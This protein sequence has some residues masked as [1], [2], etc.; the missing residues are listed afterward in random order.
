MAFMKRV[1][2][3][4]STFRLILRRLGWIGQSGRP[5][6]TLA[7]VL[8]ACMFAVTPGRA[9]AVEEETHLF[10]EALSLT[11]DCQTTTF[12]L[13]A[14]PGCPGGVHPPSP[15]R[16]PEGVAVDA[17]GNRYVAS[18]GAR[19]DGSEARIDVF[20]PS[21]L[22]IT[23]LVAAGAEAIAVD[24]DGNLYVA[25]TGAP[26]LVR[27]SPTLY[28]PQ[29][30]EI[31]YGEAPVTVKEGFGSYDSAPAINPENGQVF[32]PDTSQEDG[33]VEIFGSKAEGNVSLGMIGGNMSEPRSVAID[34]TRRRVYVVTHFEESG[35]FVPG[36]QVFDLDSPHALLATIDDSVIPGGGFASESDQAVKVAVEEATG[37]FF[38]GELSL[39]SP[40]IYEFESDGTYVSTIKR[41]GWQPVTGGQ[42]AFDNSAT[43]PTL[44]YLFAT[45]G[46][47]PP[48]RSLA[49]KPK[50]P[51]PDPPTIESVSVD[52]VAETEALLKATVDADGQPADYRFEYVTEQ[53]FDSTD[54]A[55]AQV[56]GEGTIPA[57]GKPQAVSA[58]ATAL[59]PGTKY[60]F[61]ASAQSSAGKGESVGAF[62]THRIPDESLACP[63]GDR[64]TGDSATLPD[65]RAYELVT[66]SDTNGRSPESLTGASNVGAYFASRP[67]SP[68]GG[69]V[70]FLT[71]GGAIPGYE[72]SGHLHG[73]PYLATRGPTG[74]GTVSTGPSGLE[75][76]GLVHGSASPDQTYSFWETGPA[77]TAALNGKPTSYVRYPDGHSELIGQG[78]L[79]VAQQVAGRMLSENGGHVIFQTRNQS[80]SPA[81]Q[82][83]EDAPPDGTEA[84]YDRTADGVTHVVSLL[85]GDVKQSAG[86]NAG[87]IGASLDG[88]GVAFSMGSQGPIYLRVDNTETFAAAPSG[89]VFAGVAEGGQRLFFVDDG[90]LYVFDAGSGST[91]R[92]TESGVVN[93]TGQGDV[94]VVNVAA[95]GIAAYV[96]SPSILD[97]GA[98]PNEDLPVQGE[99]NLYISKE[100]SISFVGTV[101]DRDVEGVFDGIKVTGGLGLWTTA[102]GG[103][104][105]G[106]FGIDP[107]RTTPDGDVLLFESRADLG[108]YEPDGHAQ[109][110]RYDSIAGALS[111]LSC[112]PTLAEPTGDAQ[113][114]SVKSGIDD[115][116]P[117]NALALLNNLRADGKRAFFESPDPLVAADV[118]DL[119]DV[120]EWEDEGVGSCRTEGGCVYLISS[121]RSGRD[122][123]LFGVSDSGDDVF[124]L[125]P[126]L[127]LPHLDPDETP[128][129]YDARVNGGFPPPSERVGACLGEA[130]QPS[131]STPSDLTP[132]SAAFVGRGNLE[133]K[134]KR[135][136][137]CPK[138]KRQVRRRGKTRCVP[139]GKQPRKGKRH[140]QAGRAG[141]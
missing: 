136:A 91:V 70:S 46:Y 58:P 61:R 21:G 76:P 3:C 108:D 141:R 50:P 132:A 31:E 13:V 103:S 59:V 95:D 33:G 92:F 65:C 90:D 84:I 28:H 27:Y 56:A 77:G 110:Y 6:V 8:L 93:G 54:F 116:K 36:V 41:Q 100:G 122:N 63:N 49:F 129:I 10:D 102:V 11:G 128:S 23:E 99:Q 16:K 40:R 88:R 67:V 4:D 51:A 52:D 97:G 48:G 9:L 64:R 105:P 125:T 133:E 112:V 126:D 25:R 101:T 82:L 29:T 98:N 131:V 26:P 107:S 111:C 69:R 15:I 19:E 24:G 12:D 44:G 42:I 32:F 1:T 5:I 72:G 109:I 71:V 35:K 119:Q 115:P 2:T 121:G 134:A 135:R 22:F 30:S 96:V 14:D 20:G 37:R 68:A 80:G 73:D 7:A 85:P 87:Y 114:N 138:G 17:Y 113:L 55:G 47:A 130:C 120:Y 137:R 106:K 18:K 43:S 127:L 60:R 124:I 57:S 117:A 139:R 86:Q 38:V 74:W 39:S 118:D 53:A 62:I 34:V 83:E 140:R 94:T 81:P 75:A 79:G 123:Y 89:S 78:D 66:P 104:V 45:A